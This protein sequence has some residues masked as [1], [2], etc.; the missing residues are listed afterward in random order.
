M[1]TK[2]AFWVRDGYLFALLLAQ[3]T[4]AMLSFD[5]AQRILQRE[6]QPLQTQSLPF[7][8]AFGRVLAEDI[9]SPAALPRFDNS[10]M[11][12]FALC[13]QTAPRRARVAFEVAAG[14]VATQVLQPGQV[15]RV[16]TGARMPEG[17]DCVVPQEKVGYEGEEVLL[18]EG[19]KPGQHIRKAGEDISRG[20]LLL[21]AGARLGPGGLAAL[22]AAGIAEVVAHRQPR[23]VLLSTGDEL[24]PPLGAPPPPGYPPSAAAASSALGEASLYDANSPMLASWA[25]S[26][27]ARVY[28]EHLP[29]DKA[30]T[31]RRLEAL[32]PDADILTTVGGISVGRYD[33]VRETLTDMGCRFAFSGVAM[34]PG[35][36]LCLGRLGRC[37]MLG[38]PGNPGAAFVG[39]VFF[40]APL[41]RGLQGERQAFARPVG[42]R[43][44]HAAKASVERLEIHCAQLEWAE[45]EARVKL[46][47]HFSSGAIVPLA[48]CNALV[49]LRKPAYEA[50]EK[51]EAF[52][53]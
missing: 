18:P 24:C 20:Q 8:E 3:G 4:F 52:T 29:D 16:F 40:L 23:L 26:L 33:W 39:F 35:K 9:L 48:L 50:G 53:F 47:P 25:Q 11:D 44:S 7:A 43:L 28:C 37:H 14:K 19:L 41:L 46:A 31:R 13:V 5:E 21:P 38:L 2:L 22:A 49:P 27:G 36:P 15:A 45:G 34:K 10:A 1:A 51:V 6:I 42:A 17:A 32:L 12:G 30:T